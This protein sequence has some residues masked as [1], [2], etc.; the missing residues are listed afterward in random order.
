MLAD[1]LQFLEGSVNTNLVLPALSESGRNAL[2]NV[3]VGEVV[4]QTTGQQGIYVYNGASW[5]YGLSVAQDSTNPTTLYGYGI[6]DAIQA[7]AA[8]TPGTGTKITYDA[9]GLVTGSTTLDISDIPNLPTSKLTGKISVAQLPDIGIV[10][11]TY[12]KVYTDSTGRVVGGETNPTLATLGI[13]DAIQANPDIVAGTGIKITYDAKGLVLSSDSLILDDIPD[14]PTS[15]LTGQITTAQLPQLG[16]QTAQYYRVAIDST[17]RVIGG[18]NPTTLA[19]YGITDAMQPNEAITAGTGTKITYDAK[20]LVL[21][22]GSLIASDIPQLDASVIATGRFSTNFL[23]F[24]DGLTPGTYTKVTID[25]TGRVTAGESPTT[26]GEYGITD[27]IQANTPITAGT[28]TKI[29]YDAKGLVTSSTSLVAADIPDLSATKIVSGKLPASVLPDSGVVAGDFYKVHVDVAGRVTTGTANLTPA[30]IDGL[31]AT[32]D[33]KVTSAEI[34]AAVDAIQGGANVNGNTLKKVYDLAVAGSHEITVANSSARATTYVATL[35]TNIFVLDDGDGEWALYKALA[36][37]LATNDNV[38]KLSDPNILN[39]AIGYA[40]ESAGN[41]DTDPTLT[42]NSDVK[43]PSQKAVKTYADTKIPKHTLITAGSGA[44]V[45]FNQFGLVT[46]TSTLDPTDI[47]AIDASK[48]TSGVLP[49]SA[50]PTVGVDTSAAYVKVHVDSHGRVTAGTSSLDASDIP[51]IDASK[52][53]T[54]KLPASALPTPGLGVHTYSKVTVDGS[55]LVTSGSNPT[56]IVDLGITDVVVANAPITAGTGTRISYDAKGLVTGASA[57]TANDI[58]NISAAKITTGVLPASALPLTGVNEGIYK[59]VTVDSHGRVIAGNA[60]LALDDV[61]GLVAALN[62]KISTAASDISIQAAITSLKNGVPTEGATL[63]GLYDLIIAGAREI[64]VADLAE[65][66]ALSITNI[67][68]TVFVRDDGDAKWALYKAL[69]TDADF[70]AYLETH[71]DAVE[72]DR[73]VKL[74]DQSAL[75]EA[76]GT[77]SEIKTNKSNSVTLLDNGAASTIKYPTQYAVKN[78]VD[79]QLLTVASTVASSLTG[80]LYTSALPDGADLTT[81]KL[82]LDNDPRLAG[83]AA[84]AEHVHDITDVTGLAEA[85]D[86]KISKPT[87][88]TAGTGTKITYNDQGLV[89]GSAALATS[90]LPTLTAAMI[91]GTFIPSQ[92]PE[93]TVYVDSSG[94]IP[95]SKIPSISLASTVPFVDLAAMNADTTS[96]VG[97]IGIVASTSESYIKSDT[98]WIKLNVPGGAV[99]SINGR[100]GIIDKIGTA[101]IIDGVFD[102]D[103]SVPTLVPEVLPAFTGDVTSSV[104]TNILTLNDVTDLIPDVFYSSVK[105]NSKGI[106]IAAN[107]DST[108]SFDL[109][110]GRY[111]KQVDLGARDTAGGYVG[112]TA[113]GVLNISVLPAFAGDVTSSAGSNTLTLKALAG[114]SNTNTFSSVTVNRKGLVTGGSLQTVYNSAQADARFLS[115]G[116]SGAKNTAGGFAGLD[117]DAVLYPSQLPAFIGDVTSVA[118]SRT[119]T[120]NNIAGLD[121]TVNYTSF[122]VNSKG[123]VVSGTADPFYSQSQAD[124]KYSLKSEVG[125]LATNLGGK[126]LANG[127]CGLNAFARI[128]SQYLPLLFLNDRYI[129]TTLEE[130]NA[131]TQARMGDLAI[132][133]GAIGKCF[134]LNADGPS[135][136]NNWV[137]LVTSNSVAQINGKTGIVELSLTD[138]NG[139]LALSKLPIRVTGDVLTNPDTRDLVLKDTGV[140][141]L[142]SGAVA[143]YTKVT[144]NSKGLVTAGTNP[145]TLAGYG[146]IDAISTDRLPLNDNGES[147]LLSL[148]YDGKIPANYVL[149]DII[150]IVDNEFPIE[151]EF[152]KIYILEGT[153]DSFHWTGSEYIQLSSIDASKLTLG[154]LAVGRLPALIGDATSSAGSNNL[155]LSNSGVTAGTYT[156]VTVDAKGRVT[157]GTSAPLPDAYTTAQSDARYVNKTTIGTKNTANSWVALNSDAKIDSALLPAITISDIFPVANITERDALTTTHIGDMALVGDIGTNFILSGINPRVWTPMANPLGGVTAVN[158]VT[159]SVTLNLGNIS[160]VLK[161]EALPE[162]IGD[163]SSPEGSN[164]LTIGKLNG[165]T[166]DS[167][168]SNTTPPAN[169][170]VLAYSALT[171]KATWQ[172]PSASATALT[173]GTLP[174]GRLP[175]FAGDVTSF[176]GNNE[177]TVTK[178]NGIPLDLGF[179]P[180]ALPTNG[181]VMT[182]STSTSKI[183][184]KAMDASKI[185]AGTLPAARLPA[186]TGDVTA[187]AGTGTLALSTTGVRAG[188]YNSVTVDAKG[189]VTAGT[190]VPVVDAYTKV[191]SDTKYVLKSVLGNKNTANGY[192]GLNSDKKIEAVLLPAITLNIIF[193]VSTIAQRDALAT[194][195]IG[196]V[197]IV[198]GTVNR[199]YVL[200]AI[201]PKV[202]IELANPLGGVLS[203]NGSTGVVNLTLDNIEGTLSPASLPAFTGDV[204]S[205]AGDTVLELNAVGTAGTYYK[206]TTDEKGRVVSGASSLVASD[207]PVL[208]WSKITSGIPTTAEGFGIT[209]VINA[210]RLPPGDNGE[211]SLVTVGGNGALAPS[212]MPAF[213][214][215]ATSTL[216]TTNLVLATTGVAAGTYTQVTVDTK[217]RVTSGSYAPAPDAYTKSETDSKYVFK[218]TIGNRNAANGFAGLDGSGKL[219]SSV[220][221][222]IAINDIFS[223]STI[224]ERDEL[225]TTHIG[226][227]AI[228][229][230]SV[231]TNY[232]LSGVSPRA[233]TAMSSPVGGVTSVNGSTGAV[234]VTLDNIPGALRLDSLPA[235]TGDVELVSGSSI[236]KLKKINGITLDTTNSDAAPPNDGQVLSYSAA[237]SKATWK[238]LDASLLSAGTLSPNVFPAFIGDIYSTAGN[239]SLSVVALNGIPLDT[240]YHAYARPSDSYVISYNS[241][242]AKATW[243]KLN[244]SKISTGTLP[245]ARLPEFTGDVTATAGTNTLTLVDTGVAAGTY[246]SVTVDSKGRVVAGSIQQSAGGAYTKAQSDLKYVA[247]STLGG[248]NEINGFVGLNSERKIDAVYLPDIVLNDII[249]VSTIV[250]RDALTTSHIGD[251]VIIGGT[252]NKTFILASNTPRTWVEIINPTG[253]VT[254]VNGNTGNINLTLS[255]IT[256]TLNVSALP[257]LTGDVTSTA[258]DNTLSLVDTGT[259]GTYLKVTTDAKGRVTEGVSVL[260]ATDIPSLNWSKIAYGKPTSV[261]GFGITDAIKTSRLPDGD[262]GTD[263]LV[264]IDP[265]GKISANLLPSLAITETHV[266][267]DAAATKD[268]IIATGSPALTAQKGDVAIVVGAIKA[269][270]ILVSNTP[271]NL[272]DWVP[273]RATTDGVASVNGQ[274]GAAIIDHAAVDG[275]SS[276]IITAGTYGNLVLNAK[277]RV[278]GVNSNKY[279]VLNSN[280][281]L[282]AT[283]LPGFAGGDVTSSDGSSVLTLANTG[284]TPGSYHVVTVDAKGRVT[285]GTADLILPSTGV[286]AGSYRSVTVDTTGR[287]TSAYNPTTLAEYGITDALQPMNATWDM[288]LAEG[289]TITEVGG[290]GVIVGGVS[291]VNSKIG[292]V[293][294]TKA[295][296]GLDNVANTTDMDKPVSTATQTALNSKQNTLVSGTTIK[297]INGVSVLGNGDITISGGGG[298]VTAPGYE[299]NFL[300]MGA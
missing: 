71:P 59:S 228:V 210:S 185:L 214:G 140:N 201:Q 224:A 147:R 230:G 251:L 262:N 121:T 11:N 29:T 274:T 195:H 47:P 173:S 171:S 215:D 62:A 161:T 232:I 113:S 211:T 120:L 180:T 101:D 69:Y 91:T 290:G 200:S 135:D 269:T 55:G 136:P 51:A 130:R 10:A 123:L 243:T 217:G 265:D 104:G 277:G 141:A 14:I 56:S 168:F 296:I 49:A 267:S 284:V 145:T 255:N 75:D 181:Y 190:A 100:M 256:G 263:K 275:V 41:K 32:L 79:T 221:P 205:T 164:I 223:V 260:T 202:W 80:I 257:I 276:D 21:S 40:P 192:V 182:Y 105:V 268:S 30:D 37:G 110:D 281:I 85:L 68:T 206:I 152:G 107:N 196:D 89:T 170:Y 220:I 234:S 207:I 188:T 63:K 97:T 70:G 125:N 102:P 132:V 122:K 163:V 209:D 111:V 197:A 98:G 112:L 57:L 99:T 23:P 73:Y 291:S 83:T 58:P 208:P 222:T 239:T 174:A 81:S 22:S 13:T 94:K 153:H 82:V 227:I 12:V 19:G 176:I 261:D 137:E 293:V 106:V 114:L 219:S 297:T 150:L 283:Q 273:L 1:G 279:A 65:R 60:N 240:A 3:N 20:G 9:N 216:G 119:L 272:T 226:D 61:T 285:G 194:N 54:G 50:L 2:V 278:T 203:L 66:N 36:P 31:Q 175:A 242:G 162:L 108:F 282:T 154:T 53:T 44:K 90:D 248:R 231:N 115:I 151:G 46:G 72:S 6:T 24:I 77:G 158:G 128:D 93:N 266:F 300:L 178:L 27:A 84:P 118:G 165:I 288:F 131:L 15:K 237:T 126:G 225:T 252:V 26:L 287:V 16:N 247:K 109:T 186:F 17:G 189:R 187:A 235:F 167:A 8:I 172:A 299:A 74:S 34:S 103:L 35:P 155:T 241:S 96:A 244:A 127:Y 198:G 138:I 42:A 88:L 67:P 295:D 38:V 45:T 7:N 4:F 253:G 193:A 144:V 124:A 139:T 245:V 199:T 148:G 134:I 129:V 43:F 258:G 179:S 233:W 177:L 64:S 86:G 250:E 212:I 183:A 48:I 264:T 117:A 5:Q 133:N 246:N 184:W 149:S 229:G 28:G 78:Y 238:S 92:L 191:V 39:G 218:T 236:L 289:E 286:T 254:S 298:S 87:G 156:Q 142:A 249:V 160:G 213:T 270:Y 146:I 76:L 95:S 52:I 280:N 143:Q 169:N 33:T 116:D 157:S 166:L 18:S 204:T 292:T 25:S 259:A 159:G 294:L 271:G